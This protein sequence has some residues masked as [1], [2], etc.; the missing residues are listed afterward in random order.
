ML[1]AI[2]ETFRGLDG[3]ELNDDDQTLTL[4][5]VS[6]GDDDKGDS[7]VSISVGIN[8]DNST[9]V[10]RRSKVVERATRAMRETS[11]F[12]ILSKW[13][14]ELYPVFGPNDDSE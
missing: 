5:Q 12:E 9:E 2:G 1:P 14:N 10:Q 3:W 4:L 11:H 8:T 13:R 6:S 7:S